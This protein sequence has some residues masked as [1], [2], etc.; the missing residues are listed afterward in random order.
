MAPKSKAT[1]EPSPR[2]KLSQAF[3]EALQLDF[4]EYGKA[5]IEEMRQKD[6]TR[7]AELAG[8]LIMTF[9]QPAEGSWDDCKSMEDIGRK[10]LKSVGCV[11]DVMTDGIVQAAIEANDIFIAKLEQIRAKAEGEIH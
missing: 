7:Y 8:K 5:V 9:E 1:L 4:A 3:L 11:E 6:P 2:A 10:L